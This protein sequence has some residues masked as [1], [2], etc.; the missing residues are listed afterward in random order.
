MLDYEQ[1]YRELDFSA[2]LHSPL[3]FEDPVRDL[4]SGRNIGASFTF[5][6]RLR[7]RPGETTVWGGINGHGKSLM[8]GQLGLQFAMIGQ[9]SAIM[10]F[11]MTPQRTLYRMGR[12]FMRHPLFVNEVRP[13]LEKIDP[14]FLLLNSTG[15]ISP[16]AV[17]GACI[18]AARDFKCEHIFIDNLMKLITAEDDFTGQKQ[19]IQIFHNLAM[20][21][22]CH[23]HIVHH[24][25]KG[26]DETEAINKYSFRGSSAIIDLTDNAILIQKNLAKEKKREDG[27]L[28]IEEDADEGDSILRIVKQRNGDFTGEVPVWFDPQSTAFCLD[29]GRRP[30][31][32]PAKEIEN[33]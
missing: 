1:V 23:I 12:Q 32:T 9:K 28:S 11:E 14:F 22:E 3:D 6:P 30:A 18:V 2:K 31:W 25:R 7:F 16:E 8:M 4:A 13:F 17:Y 26:K 20:D 15:D 24:V 27:K 5:E 33:E 19:A 21:F 29:A 10:S